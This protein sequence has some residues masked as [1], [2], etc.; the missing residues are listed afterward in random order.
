MRTV[1]PFC[2]LSIVKNECGLLACATTDEAD[3]V[4]YRPSEGFWGL[5]T[6]GM[7]MHSTPDEIEKI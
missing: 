6:G 1:R 7:G 2:G 5:I 4:S 3:V